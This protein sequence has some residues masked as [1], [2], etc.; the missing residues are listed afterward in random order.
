ML[1]VFGGKK[2]SLLWN[3]MQTERRF[4]EELPR[5]LRDIKPG[6]EFFKDQATH[7]GRKTV[8]CVCDI[9]GE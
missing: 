4:M 1:A 9:K 8:V 7:E 3:G 5:I 2:A 6:T